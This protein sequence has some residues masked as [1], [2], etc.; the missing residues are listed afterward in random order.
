MDRLHRDYKSQKVNRL[1][2]VR[3]FRMLADNSTKGLS[4]LYTIVDM[5]EYRFKH[6]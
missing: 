1:N 4:T 6:D 5:N 3:F 2:D